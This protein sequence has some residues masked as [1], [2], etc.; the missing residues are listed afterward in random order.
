MENKN[1]NDLNLLKTTETLYSC[2][3][4]IKTPKIIKIDYINDTIE[5]KCE[6]HQITKLKIKD[7]L[8]EISKL[9]KCQ[10]CFKESMNPNHPLKFCSTC[11]LPLCNNCAMEHI[12][13]RHIL[14]NK[15]DYNIKCKKHLNNF[16]E[17]FCN[18]CKGSICK[19]CKK[20]GIHFKHNK[21]D[22]IEI[23]PSKNDFDIIYNFNKN[24]E[25][26][27]NEL[28]YDKYMESLT[29]EQNER[30][31]LINLDYEKYK[32]EI[33]NKYQI[34]YQ[35][36]INEI[37]RQKKAELFTLEQKIGVFKKDI[38][39]EIQQRK[40]EYEK[41]RKQIEK[42]KDI[43]ELNNLIIT[44]YKKQGEYNLN[45]I[46]NIKTAIEDIKYYIEQNQKKDKKE[47]KNDFNLSE[48]IKKYG[49]Y[50][51]SKLNCIKGKNDKINNELMNNIFKNTKLE[52]INIC[53]KSLNSL[54]FLKNNSENLK[55]LLMVDCPISDINILSKVNLNSLIEL[56]IANAKINNINALAGNNLNNIK[57]L[58]LS[59]NQIKDINILQ[60]V[61]FA[62]I[63]E[64]LYLNNNQ[65]K[66]ISVFNNN[67]FPI[68]KILF[69]SFNIIED[70]SPIKSILINSCQIL[71]LEK[72]QIH[73]INLFKDINRF[74]H[75]K[76]L[77]IKQNLIDINNENNK[78]IF[79]AIKEK[80]I[81]FQY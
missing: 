24:L 65:I 20:S 41:N 11:N 36:Y 63:L 29:K 4:C 57:V 2:H 68:L 51:D 17:A 53:S 1:K 77:S 74:K 48:E 38:I 70:I 60:K 33:E 50:M 27:I 71:S 9:K 22:Y 56:K 30:I 42:N 46:E 13:S 49:L 81:N 23:Q 5:L 52:L 19:E 6:E 10:K 58:N 59:N 18:N 12:D 64:E 39:K 26:Q 79:K 14:F 73:D 72:N 25:K 3:K 66:D 32:K 16:Y 28:D 69:L 55:F 76:D 45:Y 47:T 80:N 62:N 35:Q 54:D 37:T 44:S 15:D 34:I 8:N 75:L 61:N 67:I 31:L 7:Y 78:N 21:F 40:L 43:I